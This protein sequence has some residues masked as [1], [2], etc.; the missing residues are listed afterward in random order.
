MKQFKR[1]SGALIAHYRKQAKMTQAELCEAI[2]VSPRQTL[3]RWER[4]ESEIKAGW[5][6]PIAKA[7]G[8][9]PGDLLE[10]AV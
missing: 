9:K 6:T 2:G 3:S 7:L 4:G 5:I 10:D 8:V 1:A